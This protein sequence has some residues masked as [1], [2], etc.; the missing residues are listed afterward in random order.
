MVCPTEPKDRAKI[1]QYLFDR[2][3][4]RGEVAAA[5]GCSREQLRRICLPFDDEQWRAPSMKLKQKVAVWTQGAIG[6]D[7]WEVPA[8]ARAREA[9]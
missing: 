5:L 3:M 1:A 7:D 4:Q 9:A 8:R 6:L 2:T